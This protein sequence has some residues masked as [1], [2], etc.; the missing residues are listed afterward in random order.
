LE[1][2]AFFYGMRIG[3]EKPDGGGFDPSGKDP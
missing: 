2:T 1:E 3:A